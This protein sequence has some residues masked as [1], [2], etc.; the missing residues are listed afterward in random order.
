MREYFTR[1]LQH[2]LID[3][4]AFSPTPGAS[5]GLRKPGSDQQYTAFGDLGNTPPMFVP[6]FVFRRQG[7]GAGRFGRGRFG[8]W[9]GRGRAIQQLVQE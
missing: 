2:L 9:N 8:Q 5:Q 1:K 7:E 3:P 6:G 4:L